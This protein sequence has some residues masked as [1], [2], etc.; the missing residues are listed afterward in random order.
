MEKIVLFGGTFDPVTVEHIAVVRSLLSEGFTK[1]I[2]VP[3]YAPPHKN[4]STTKVS[5]R[6]NMLKLCFNN[7]DGVEISD[8]EINQ[9]RVVYSYETVQYFS[10]LYG[11]IYFA[12]GT[13]MLATFSE[14]RNPEIIAKLAQIVLIKRQGGGDNTTAIQNFKQKY[15]NLIEVGYEGKDVSS[16]EVRTFYKLN[17]PLD[18]LVTSEVE[19][20]IK[21]NDIYKKDRLYDYI[22]QVL[23]IKRRKHT[24]G[25]IVLAK[26]FAKRL[27]VDED[28]AE[29]ASLLHDNAKYLNYLDFHGFT[30]PESMPKNVIHQ[31][32][33]AY[34]A[35]KILGIQDEQILTAIKYHTT[36]RAGMSPLE[37][38]VF[39]A[40]V[41]EK[42][43]TF[44]GV[45]KLREITEADFEK[46][47]RLSV[48]DLYNSLGE[49]LYHLTCEVYKLCVEEIKN[50]IN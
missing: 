25:V 21:D 11:R 37:K 50:G 45:E 31:F 15:G 24:A 12:M 1:V 42:S 10:A 5:D 4:R 36:G 34:V 9:K 13:D 46:G 14:W 30:L 23:P 3:T 38:I 27:G 43:R 19:K 32:L 29:I 18:G 26:R 49:D 7:F 47:F 2:I 39:M 33:G 35:E 41:L 20:Y 17:L 44:E 8:Y 48:I 16:T 40:D 28:K 6:L 22:C